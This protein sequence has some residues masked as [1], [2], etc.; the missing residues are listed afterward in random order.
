ML[1]VEIYLGV[2]RGQEG[3]LR[4]PLHVTFTPAL[5]VLLLDLTS[6]HLG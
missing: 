1:I 6:V 5:A 2:V 3:P 4:G